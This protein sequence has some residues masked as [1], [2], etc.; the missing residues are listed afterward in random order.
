MKK[1]NIDFDNVDEIVNNFRNL[2]T[3]VKYLLINKLENS[4]DYDFGE[5]ESAQLLG[6]VLLDDN[7]ADGAL[8]M[9]TRDNEKFLGHFG[10]QSIDVLNQLQNEVGK[11]V[12]LNINNL[13]LNVV[14]TVTERI[15][16]S[17]V[18]EDDEKVTKENLAKI[19]DNLK[20]LDDDSMDFISD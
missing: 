15:L 5:L 7:F 20:E 12:G 1:E 2:D 17:V 8:F 3:Y 10:E 13:I 19:I 11:V 9:Y 4:D 18:D 14:Q 6:D 16:D